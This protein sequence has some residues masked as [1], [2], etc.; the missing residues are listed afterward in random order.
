MKCKVGGIVF[1]ECDKFPH[2]N[3]FWSHRMREK[4]IF[5]DRAL[6]GD[7]HTICLKKSEK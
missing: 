1:I 2:I 3:P 7:I 5:D 4:G 6:K